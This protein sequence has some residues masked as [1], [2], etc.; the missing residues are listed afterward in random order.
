MDPIDSKVKLRSKVSTSSKPKYGVDVIN[1]QIT[2]ISVKEIFEPLAVKEQV[3]N[4]ATEA[5][6]MIL[7]ID[8]VIAAGK[9]K[10]PSG[11]APG[12]Y[13]GYGGMGEGM[14]EM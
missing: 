10:T 7:R 6:S 12:G 11:P 9:S 5:S 8:N 13:G 1:S 3:I 14:P 2:D 4:A